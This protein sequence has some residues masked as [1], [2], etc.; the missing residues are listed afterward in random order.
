MRVVLVALELW[1]GLQAVLVTILITLSA[2]EGRQARHEA[3]VLEQ[4]YLAPS[5]EPIRQD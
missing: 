3:A 2:I 5:V 1:L 4:Q